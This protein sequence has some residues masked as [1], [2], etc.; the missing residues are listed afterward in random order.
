MRC[1]L[2]SH[3]LKKL[4]PLFPGSQTAPHL[5]HCQ[6]S[7]TLAISPP[8]CPPVTKV[9]VLITHPRGQTPSGCPQ[10]SSRGASDKKLFPMRPQMPSLRLQTPAAQPLCLQ[11]EDHPVAREWMCSH[12]PWP[13]GMSA[14][15]HQTP[16][17]LTKNC[18]ASPLRGGAILELPN[19][20]SYRT[21]FLLLLKSVPHSTP[22]Q[23]L[24]SRPNNFSLGYHNHPSTPAL[25]F[26]ISLHMTITAKPPESNPEQD[27]I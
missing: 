22:A 16:H 24:Q 21:C 1:Q 27:S 23:V 10:T 11:P 3:F 26:S 19:T 14:P 12:S 6:H 25:P 18:S 2:F 17:H 15:L 13:G 20:K 4:A 7:P 9:Y 5:L 8:M